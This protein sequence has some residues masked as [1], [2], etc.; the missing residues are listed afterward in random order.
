MRVSLIVATDLNGVIG[1]DNQLP[2]HLPADLKHFKKLTMGCPMIMGR[3]THESIGRALP[4]RRNLVITRQTRYESEGCEIYSSFRAALEGAE[5]CAEVMIIGGA[6]IYERALPGADRVYQTLVH[7]AVPGD[8]HF[9]PLTEAEWRQVD[10]SDHD[11]DDRNPHAYSFLT[12]DRVA[13]A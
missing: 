11:A 7:A 1:R 8:T 4:G 9:P 2:W 12:W 13:G 10:R 5:P 6:T 3:K